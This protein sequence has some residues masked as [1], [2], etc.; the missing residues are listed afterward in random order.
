MRARLHNHRVPLAVLGIVALA[1][2]ARLVALEA[3][4]AHWDEAR[5]GWWILQYAA[6]GTYE[7]Y[8]ILHGPFLFHVNRWVFSV[9]GPSDLAARLVVAVAGSL[10]P[11]TA[12]ALHGRLDAAETVALAALLAADP[13]LLYHSRFMRNDVLVAAFS[14]AAFALLVASHDTGRVRYA[15][16]AAPVLALAFATKE[17]AILYVLCWVGAAVLAGVYR[18]RAGAPW[19]DLRGHARA[20]AFVAGSHRRT[21]WLAVRRHPAALLASVAAFLGVIVVFYAPRGGDGPTLGAALADPWLWP[22]VVG[23]A[24]LTPARKLVDL[25][26]LG[27]LGGGAYPWFLLLLV[28]VLVVPSLAV[29]ALAAVGVRREHP[30]PRPLVTLAAAWA[31]LSLLGYPLAVDLVGGWT[32]VHVVVPL[33]VPAA[34]GLVALARRARSALA[35][36]RRG[37]TPGRPGR[38][39]A[40]ALLVL[41][42]HVVAVGGLTSYWAPGHAENALAQP[43]QPDEDLKPTVEAA[44]AV[45]RANEGLD[46]A[47][48]GA[49]WDGGVQRRFPL[50]WYFRAADHGAPADRRVRT[51]VVT[52][53]AALEDDA[54]PVVVA[55]SY[56]RGTIADALD[57]YECF[58]HELDHWVDREPGGPATAT[59]VY[60][61]ADALAAVG[62]RSAYGSTRS[63]HRCGSSS[64]ASLGRFSGA[65]QTVPAAASPR[66]S[67]TASK[68][69]RPRSY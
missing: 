45:A 8:P 17:N 59:H 69:A 25:W 51:A 4:V 6:T 33:T 15:V 40:L 49:Y 18:E 21:A 19:R 7:Y 31:L 38:R 42:A 27:D 29:V 58:A 11:L 26:L 20:T 46:V 34:V 2:A 55:L 67:A 52:D 43:A 24:T 32:S 62:G 60:V 13:V 16:A 30:R 64:S 12:L 65:S 35:A 56:Q 10:L 28:I 5:V 22:A 66:S 9:L 14:F 41:S 48:Y 39:A 36:A 63:S 23:A 61:D 37:V 54:P 44:V 53:R 68:N 50:A 1:A 57:G 47:Y 3:R